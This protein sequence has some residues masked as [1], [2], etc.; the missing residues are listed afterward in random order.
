MMPSEI[1]IH[2]FL[3]FLIKRFAANSNI[4]NNCIPSEYARE[5]ASWTQ[6]YLE[7]TNVWYGITNEPY[8]FVEAA[9]QCNDYGGQLISITNQTIDQ[10]SFEILRSNSIIDEIIL[11]SGRYSLDTI[12]RGGDPT[13][14][15]LGAL[16]DESLKKYR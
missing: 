15:I 9:A 6:C 10:C 8:D 7:S 11:Y 2:V 3:V 14:T 16:F 13:R 1:T 5:Q 4:L 12:R